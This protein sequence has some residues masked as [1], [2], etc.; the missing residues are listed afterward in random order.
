MVILMTLHQLY[1]TKNWLCSIEWAR[2]HAPLAPEGRWKSGMVEKMTER[3]PGL[4]KMLRL[5]SKRAE[6]FRRLPL[7]AAK[8]IR[9]SAKRPDF[10][11]RSEC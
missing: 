11:S 3:G 8:P 4:A 6:A 10:A 1:F 9:H 2:T 5:D 7:T